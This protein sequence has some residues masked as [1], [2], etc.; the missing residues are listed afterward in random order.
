MKREKSPRSPKPPER[1]SRPLKKS[2]HHA[3]ATEGEPYAE[4][5]TPPGS[6]VGEAAAEYHWNEDSAMLE[7]TSQAFLHAHGIRITPA[8]M[9]EL[10]REAVARLP[11]NLYRSDPRRDL[12]AAEV[13][14]LEEGGFDLSPEPTVLDPAADP[15][16]RTAAELAALL[17]TSLSTLQAAERLGVDPSRIRQRLTAEPPTLY[18]IRRESG[19]VL[20]EF[21]FD[22]STLLPGMGEIVA[23]L[24]PELHPVAVHRW[25][26][27]PNVD[28][29][30]GD[31]VSGPLS[32][33]D[34]LRLGFPPG[35]VVSLAADL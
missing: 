8:Q 34:W 23:N 35:A 22:G 14:I 5:V 25:F 24:D 2:R 12:T 17:K 27:L 3:T 4:L 31:D 10:V 13:A 9:D 1:A 28:L 20:P 30:A 32:P 6:E 21:Q 29:D 26:T 33:R 15:L 19:W 11:R 7:S 16:A 18:G